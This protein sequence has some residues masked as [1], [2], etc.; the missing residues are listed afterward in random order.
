MGLLAVIVTGLSRVDCNR[1]REAARVSPTSRSQ[2][3]KAETSIAV[4]LDGKTPALNAVAIAQLA[5]WSSEPPLSDFDSFAATNKGQIRGAL[6]PPGISQYHLDV[7]GD[8]LNKATGELSEY[9]SVIRL[10]YVRAK[11]WYSDTAGNRY[12]T[13][14]CMYHINGRPLNEFGYCKIGK[15]S[16]TGQ[17]RPPLLL[18]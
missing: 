16:R 13:T 4:S 9:A 14:I 17:T 5:T 12:W 2:A 11:V 3:W 10:L 15:R 7:F 8:K 18:R 1:T 6:L